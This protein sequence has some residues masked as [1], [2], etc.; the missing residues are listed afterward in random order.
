MAGIHVKFDITADEFLEELTD[1]AYRVALQHGIGN[2]FLEMEMDLLEAMKQV[3]Q[4]T[5]DFSPACGATEECRK[6]FRTR[7]FNS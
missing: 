7:P 3:V 2:S 5:M 1:T 6:A 4:R